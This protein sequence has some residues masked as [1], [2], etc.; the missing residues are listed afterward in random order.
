MLIVEL[1]QE[2]IVTP[3]SRQPWMSAR[4][5]KE[6][7]AE[8]SYQGFLNNFIKFL[9]HYETSPVTVP[10]NAKD[11][12]LSAISTVH[13]L[14][15][16]IRRC[17]IKA[18]KIIVFYQLS[19]TVIKLI[20]VGPHDLEEKNNLDRMC[21]YAKRLKDSD[22][23][24]NMSDKKSKEVNHLSQEEVDDIISLFKLLASSPQDRSVLEQVAHGNIGPFMEWAR[25]TIDLDIT[26]TS[27]DQIII[28]DLNGKNS[29]IALAKRWLSQ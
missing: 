14:N 16:P 5:V 2:A 22:F 8:K 4:F 21:E 3:I 29:M 26:D 25:A 19:P 24:K 15:P 1:L 11:G 17:H 20:A 6:F 12:N 18:G 28:A 13:S 10:Y 27:R 7:A 9:K 23:V